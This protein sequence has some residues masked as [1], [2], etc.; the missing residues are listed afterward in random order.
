MHVTGVRRLA[1]F[2]RQQAK[3]QGAR[4]VALWA[5]ASTQHARL[6]DRL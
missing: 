5:R 6:A 1:M 3:A 4:Y 2:V